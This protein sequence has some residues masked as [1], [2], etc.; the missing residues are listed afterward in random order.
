MSDKNLPMVVTGAASGIGAATCR[1]LTEAGHRLIGVDRTV[2]TAFPGTFIQ[3]DLSTPDGAHAAAAQVRDAAPKGISGLTNI[4]GVPGT[5][6][7]RTVLGVNVVGLRE[8]TRALLPLVVEGG[9]VV[10]L[11]SVVAEG[12]QRNIDTLRR[13]ALADDPEAALDAVA[14]GEETIDDSYRFSKECVRLLT[15]HFAAEGLPRRIR[16]NS[17]SPGPVATPILDDFKRDHGVDK[18][19][20]AGELLGRFGESEDIARVIVF[21]TRD[22]AE[23]V[24]GIDLRVDGGLTA[25]RNTRADA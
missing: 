2:A 8:L 6:P 15:E 7:W 20:G 1:L 19:E 16:V 24:N 22:E 4:A 18:V 21:L 12:W 11:S 9:V 3:A 25:Y 17:V 23:W 14:S 5:A 10:N 13:F